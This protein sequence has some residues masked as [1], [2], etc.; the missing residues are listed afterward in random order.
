MVRRMTLWNSLCQVKLMQGNWLGDQHRAAP[1]TPFQAAL[2]PAVL[3]GSAR[4]KVSGPAADSMLRAVTRC[5]LSRLGPRLRLQPRNVEVFGMLRPPTTRDARFETYSYNILERFGT[6][7]ADFAGRMD[8]FFLSN[9]FSSS[10]EGPLPDFAAVGTQVTAYSR[11]DVFG[12]KLIINPK[13]WPFLWANKG[14][15]HQTYRVFRVF[16]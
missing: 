3:S 9:E 5:P 2:L 14:L 13:L 15:N 10:K 16:P 11:C 12:W 7:R 6:L 8:L 4:P 1:S